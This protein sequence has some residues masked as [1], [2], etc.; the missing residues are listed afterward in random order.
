V[1]AALAAGA[2]GAG[3][4]TTDG[5]RAR[6]AAGGVLNACPD[7]GDF[8]PEGAC[9]RLVDCAVIPLDSSNGNTYDWRMCVRDVQSLSTIAEQAAI[10]CIFASTCDQLKT[11]DS[12]MGI[13]CLDASS[14][15]R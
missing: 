5:T 4:D 15:G 10:S 14:G 11:P 2:C 7:A 6:C 9:W 8:T 13:A 1:L 3:D 12:A